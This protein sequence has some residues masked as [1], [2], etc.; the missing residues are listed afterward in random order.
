MISFDSEGGIR[1]SGTV[2]EPSPFFDDRQA[3]TPVN[4]V[5]MH[6]TSLPAA[7][8]GLGDVRAPFL[9]HWLQTDFPAP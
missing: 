1:G 5:V 4:P 2:C 6:H 7:V 9:A 3:D 8:F